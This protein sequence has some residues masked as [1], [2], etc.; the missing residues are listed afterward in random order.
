MTICP[1]FWTI[2]GILK[3]ADHEQAKHS[4]KT[5]QISAGLGYLAA[6]LPHVGSR[7]RTLVPSP[8]P[9]SLMNPRFAMTLPPAPS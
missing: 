1:T 9:N 6:C 5:L 3:M 4:K 8:V 2:S 7:A